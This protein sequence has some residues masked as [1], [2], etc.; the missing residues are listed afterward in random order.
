MP[1][2]LSPLLLRLGEADQKTRRCA[3]TH[4][5]QEGYCQGD[6]QVARG[7]GPSRIVGRAGRQRILAALPALSIRST[8]TTFPS[9]RKARLTSRSVYGIHAV[10]P[11]HLG[12]VLERGQ[13]SLARQSGVR[14]HKPFDRLPV[15]EFLYDV[16][17]GDPGSRD[18]H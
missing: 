5:D 12:S 17:D 9:A 18:H 2:M 13:N 16:L 3:Q 8:L 15:S 4:D 6:L 7:P 1:A 11:H 14:V 10:K